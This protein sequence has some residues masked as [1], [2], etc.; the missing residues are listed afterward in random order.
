[1]NIFALLGFVVVRVIVGMLWYSPQGFW[2]LWSKETG[3]KE[4]KAKKGM[5]KAFAADLIGSLI[6]AVVLLH[7]IKY[8][9]AS[10]NL[11][12]GLAVS[13]LNWLGFVGV[14]QYAMAA[15]EQRSIRFFGVVSGYQLVSM[16]LGGIVL[17][18]WG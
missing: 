8:A 10:G 15:Y 12:L 16:L 17:T 2:K 14:V 1:M 11:L 4:E 13:F 9:G 18:L 6:M 7:A 5:P 3:I